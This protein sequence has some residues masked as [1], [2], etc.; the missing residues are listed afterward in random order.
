MP[1]KN[2]IISLSVFEVR[3]AR[4]GVADDNITS[5]VQLWRPEDPFKI[6]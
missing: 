5:L 6:W 4:M 1:A 3:S 2:P